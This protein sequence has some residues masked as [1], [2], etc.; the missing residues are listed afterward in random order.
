MVQDKGKE[1][2]ECMNTEGLMIGIN[3]R[4]TVKLYAILLGKYDDY[5]RAYS[6]KEGDLRRYWENVIEPEA[7]RFCGNAWGQNPRITTHPV[8]KALMQK[9]GY[10]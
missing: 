6:S 8:G 4:E 5:V 10:I 7:A 2:E 3:K 1:Q 9:N